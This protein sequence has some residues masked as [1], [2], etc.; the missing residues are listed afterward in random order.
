MGNRSEEESYY[1]PLKDGK[2]HRTAIET[3]NHQL[4]AE[5][6]RYEPESESTD[7]MCGTQENILE[8]KDRRYGETWREYPQRNCDVATRELQKICRQ[9]GKPGKIIMVDLYTL[10]LE[11]DGRVVATINSGELKTKIKIEA[12]FSLPGSHHP[13]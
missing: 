11:I 2:C 6:W 7:G 5:F 12:T 8:H 10:N 1:C 4:R 13:V 3:A 9:L